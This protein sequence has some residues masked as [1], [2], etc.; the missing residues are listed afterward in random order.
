MSKPRNKKHN[1][2]RMITLENEKRL[3]NVAVSYFVNDD[4]MTQEPEPI[5]LHGNVLPVTPK[6]ANALQMYKYKWSV[7][8][9]IF[10]IEKGLATIKMELAELSHKNGR[11][12]QR[13]IVGELNILHQA[14]VAKQKK[15]NVNV[16]GVG[17][18][19]SPVNRDFDEDEVG[20]IF[21]K[22]GA[23]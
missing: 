16:T 7:M 3:K 21:E 18:V 10:C 11:E 20:F 13:N 12:Y 14:F 4:D 23:F 22:L 17:W 9:C 15:L 1:P 6:L 5:D 2:L 19:A 8:L